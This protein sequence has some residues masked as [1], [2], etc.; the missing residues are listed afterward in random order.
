MTVSGNRTSAGVAKYGEKIHHAFRGDPKSNDCCPYK[1]RK[2]P[3]DTL[4][5]E[6]HVKTGVMLPWSQE[7]REPP[8]TRR[9][10]DSV[11]PQSLQKE[12]GLA[13]T[14]VLGVWPLEQ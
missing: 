9:G 5:K 14:L 3:R 4:R 8:E 13:D 10:K 2:G 11:S 1:K 12:Q 7:L 6:G